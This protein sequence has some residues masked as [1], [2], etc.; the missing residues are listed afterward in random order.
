MGTFRPDHRYKDIGINFSDMDYILQTPFVY[1]LKFVLA[2][3]C[4]RPTRVSRDCNR[5][6]FFVTKRSLIVAGMTQFWRRLFRHIAKIPIFQ[7]QPS[8]QDQGQDQV[9]HPAMGLPMAAAAMIVRKKL[10][11]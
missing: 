6:P 11:I 3:K 5:N 1:R 7:H 2:P 10:Q 4:N 9:L 8:G